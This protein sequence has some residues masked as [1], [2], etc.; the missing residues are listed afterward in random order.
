[1]TRQLNCCDLFCGG[2]GTSSGA[3]STG[4]ARVRFAVNHW[5]VAI[6]THSANFPDA[7]HVNSRLDQVSPSECPRIDLLFASPECT[8]HSRARGGRPTSDQQ[9]SGAWDVLKWIEFHR[10]S[11]VVIENVRELPVPNLK[12]GLKSWGGEVPAL[13]F[14]VAMPSNSSE[15]EGMYR[16][17]IFHDHTWPVAIYRTRTDVSGQPMGDLILD[18]S[19]SE[20]WPETLRVEPGKRLPNLKAFQR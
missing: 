11:W 12:R 5:S 18:E 2:G 15:D 4:A 20:K 6:Q 3:E 13:G 16:V 19:P 17:W 10:P 1:M 14:A 8:H 9:R 7:T